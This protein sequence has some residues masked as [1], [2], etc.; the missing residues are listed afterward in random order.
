MNPISK[1][2]I[3]FALF[4]ATKVNAQL[5]LGIDGFD[6]IVGYQYQN[7]KTLPIVFNNDLAIFT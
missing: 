3:I 1:L 6:G 7:Y 4:F 2:I 5:S